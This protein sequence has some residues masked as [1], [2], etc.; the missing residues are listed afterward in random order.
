MSDQTLY[1]D[2]TR[3]HDF[4][5]LFDVAD[6]N[7]NGDPDAGNLPRIDP[8]TMQG[9]VTDVCLKRKV[10]NYVA[11]TQDAGG[12]DIYVNDQGTALNALHKQ[13]YSDEGLSSTGTKQDRKDVEKARGRMCQTYYDVRL[14]G[15]VMTTGVNCGQVR[16]P[17][18][19]TFARSISPVAPLDISITRV[20]ITREE[21]AT[22]VAADTEAGGKGAQGKVTEMGRKAM[23]PYGLYLAHGFFSAPFA[24]RTG[25]STDDLALFW[26]AL[27]N[28]WDH[29]HSASRGMMA[30][31][32][33]YVFTHDNKLGNAPA[34]DLFARV[35]VSLR[36]GVE[37]PRRFADYTVAVDATSLPAGVTLTKLVG[38]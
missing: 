11:L 18:Q 5:L 33:L 17:V 3:R 1:T 20:A 36:D 16:G 38:A 31:R 27:Q 35:A 37:A 29:D 2:P 22:V 19:L 32:G 25:V 14:F 24:E 26:E 13:A 10:R 28:M 12:Y 8:E 30:C 21:D 6:G 15:A 7:P 34:Q 9:L 4:V 23:V